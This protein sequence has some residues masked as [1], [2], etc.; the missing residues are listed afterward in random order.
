MFL[1]QNGQLHGKHLTFALPEGFYFAV[2]RDIFGGKGFSFH[3]KDKSVRIDIFFEQAEGSA[4]EE[5]RDLFEDGEFIPMGEPISVR[6]GKRTATALFYRNE[7]GTEEYY[8]ERLPVSPNKYGENCISICVTGFV[9]KGKNLRSLREI[10]E[11]P[12]VKTFLNG[13]RYD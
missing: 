8:E 12:V 1:I 3:S 5:F 10:L 9:R 2:N 6:R 4:E 7:R 13:V 11:E